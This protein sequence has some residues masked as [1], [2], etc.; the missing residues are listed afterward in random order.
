[1]NQDICGRC[2]FYRVVGFGGWGEC[3]ANIVLPV[4]ALVSHINRATMETDECWCGCF[5]EKERS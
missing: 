3:Q 4:A 5:Q 2:K 1:M